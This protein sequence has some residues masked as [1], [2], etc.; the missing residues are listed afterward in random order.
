MPPIYPLLEAVVERLLF[1]I[2]ERIRKIGLLRRRLQLL[3]LGLYNLL[4]A[5]FKPKLRHL[6]GVVAE[7]RTRRSEPD[8]VAYT[9]SQLS[10]RFT[11]T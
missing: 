4:D 7:L 8:A 3:L 10:E 6:G 11:P 5:H 1:Q 2:C 9:M